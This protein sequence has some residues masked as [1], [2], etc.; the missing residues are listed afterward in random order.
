MFV[1]MKRS[2][3]FATVLLAAS[4]AA[5]CATVEDVAAQQIPDV[6]VDGIYLKAFLVAHDDFMTIKDL[7]QR[8]KNLRR[9]TVHFSSGDS[10]IDIVFLPKFPP[11]WFGAGGESPYGREVHYQIDAK[12]YKIKRREFAE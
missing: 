9:Y 4:V 1:P 6:A 3:L 5:L 11:G 10:Q 8:K 12:T 7:P 2:P